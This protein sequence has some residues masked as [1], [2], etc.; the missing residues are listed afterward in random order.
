MAWSRCAGM[1][2]PGCELERMRAAL[3]GAAHAAAARDGALRGLQAIED[4]SAR[5]NGGARRAQA[6][7]GGGWRLEGLQPLCPSSLCIAR[8]AKELPRR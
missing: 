5:G 7:L 6:F 2:C 1:G 4:G 8:L 3:V